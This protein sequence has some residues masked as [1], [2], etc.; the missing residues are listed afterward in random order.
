MG[1]DFHIKTNVLVK[2][3]VMGNGHYLDVGIK[4]IVS[5]YLYVLAYIPC[6]K[7]MVF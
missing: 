4:N 7:M 1:N 5:L 2:C 6:V 3:D